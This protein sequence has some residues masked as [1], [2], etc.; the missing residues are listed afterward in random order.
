MKG[1][2]AVKAVKGVVKGAIKA[3]ESPSI[4]GKMVNIRN[5]PADVHKAL[6]I[7]AINEGITVS[8]ITTRILVKA[9]N[10]AKA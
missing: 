2:K 5:L 8:E 7:M 3:G 10:K 6:R 4:K 9:V 1:K